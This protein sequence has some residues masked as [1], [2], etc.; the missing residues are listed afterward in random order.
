V[1]TLTIYINSISVHNEKYY[2]KG[3]G[4]G[5]FEVIADSLDR[6]QLLHSY[7]DYLE[8]QLAYVEDIISGVM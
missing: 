4:T 5:E 6:P 3:D 7:K 8:D 2:Y 1:A